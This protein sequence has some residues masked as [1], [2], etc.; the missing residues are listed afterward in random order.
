ME[1][2]QEQRGLKILYD[3][4][5]KA[6]EFPSTNEYSPVSF[7]KWIGHLQSLSHIMMQ[8]YSP[9][10]TEEY[11]RALNDL[12]HLPDLTA[13]EITLIKSYDVGYAI[14]EVISQSFADQNLLIENPMG[15]KI[16][17]DSLVNVA[18]FAQ[19]NTFNPSQ[20]LR[21]FHMIR[22]LN[23]LIYPYL[24]RHEREL[25]IISKGLHKGL[26]LYPSDD[27]VVK[28]REWLFNWMGLL[29]R[30]LQE[31]NML[32]PEELSFSD[33]IGNKKDK[34]NG[35]NKEI[36]APVTVEKEI[37]EVKAQ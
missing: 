36:E 1:N 25:A 4:L 2:D 17:Y 37:E 19:N 28:S 18:T 8:F 12:E 10:L 29:S 6:V 15:Q 22:G 7:T 27:Y 14:L 21:F 35:E 34:H 26:N 20:I 9:V 33:R 30:V 5:V 16:I 24:S 23:S 13:D 11:N 32:I 3:M 31:N